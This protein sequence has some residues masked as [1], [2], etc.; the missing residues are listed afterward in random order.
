MI[1][2]QTLKNL[3]LVIAKCPSV[4]MSFMINMN[5]VLCSNNFKSPDSV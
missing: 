3:Q 1:K 5:F 2:R 4:Y